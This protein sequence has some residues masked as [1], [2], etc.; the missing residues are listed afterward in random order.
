MMQS[1]QAYQTSFNPSNADIALDIDA[2][3]NSITLSGIQYHFENADKMEAFL[4]TLWDGKIPTSHQF[5]IDQ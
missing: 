5:H 2:S 1:Q 4:R 3:R